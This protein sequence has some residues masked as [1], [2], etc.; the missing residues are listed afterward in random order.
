[1]SNPTTRLSSKLKAHVDTRWNSAYDMMMSII[2]VHQELYDLL[3]SKP[4]E[5]DKLTCLPIIDMK[6]ICEHLAFF[7]NVTAVIESDKHVTLQHY[8]LTLHQMKRLLIMKPSDTNSVKAMKRA[9]LN[10][11][12]QDN[13]GSFRPNLRN[14][15]A[16]FLY[17][18]MRKLSI[19]STTE[20]KEVHDHVKDFIASQIETDR[21]L[22]NMQNEPLSSSLGNNAMS[23]FQDYFD[24]EDANDSLNDEMERYIVTKVEKVTKYWNEKLEMVQAKIFNKKSKNFGKQTIIFDDNFWDFLSTVLVFAFDIFI[25]NNSTDPSSFFL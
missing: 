8:W 19:A 15:L 5:L 2:A 21:I 17:P 24:D 3:Q 6:A 20:I 25:A 10:Y 4:T 7:K 11:I 1:M 12:E 16:T 14:K 22:S 9:G 13:T 18:P 23:L